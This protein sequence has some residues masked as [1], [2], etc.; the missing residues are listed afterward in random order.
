M[1]CNVQV[2]AC[3]PA[4]RDANMCLFILRFIFIVVFNVLNP[5]V[6]STVKSPDLIQYPA[7]IIPSP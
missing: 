6:F 2:D 4:G 5:L 1:Q 3:T 7:V